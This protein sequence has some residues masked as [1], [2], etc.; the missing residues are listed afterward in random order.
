MS[1]KICILLLTILALTQVPKVLADASSDLAEL[2]LAMNQFSA[3][4]SQQIS[5]QDGELI[6]SASG[7][8]H[9]Q[10]PSKLRWAINEPD[11]QL[12]VVDGEKMWRYE[13]DLEQVTVENYTASEQAAPSILL[14]GDVKA[15]NDKF[16]VSQYNGGFILSPKDS[17]SLF[18]Q[19]HVRF[20]D[21]LIAQLQITDGFEQIT[22]I[23]FSN[24]DI[25]TEHSSDLYSFSP[26]EGVDILRN[27]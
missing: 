7:N 19:I 13:A 23:L 9:A 26:P 18:V 27:D 17:S 12:V 16:N 14:S 10:R 3:D 24:V 20:G 21:G 1:N 25:T 6:Q 22:D 8:V 4:F 5:T 2:L 15:L 11:E